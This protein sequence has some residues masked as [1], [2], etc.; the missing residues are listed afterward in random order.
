MNFCTTDDAADF[1]NH[2]AI[3]FGSKVHSA[4]IHLG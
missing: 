4:Q 2:A 1:D 3:F